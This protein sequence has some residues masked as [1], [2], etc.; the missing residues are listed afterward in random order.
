MASA[1]KTFPTRKKNCIRCC[2]R[3]VVQNHDDGRA[4]PAPTY[5]FVSR[6]RPCTLIIFQRPRVR[7][8]WCLGWSSM[9]HSRRWRR[10]SRPSCPHRGHFCGCTF[11]LRSGSTA[12]L[13]F[14]RNRTSFL[15]RRRRGR[16]SR[17]SCIHG[18]ILP[19]RPQKSHQKRIRTF[20]F[21]V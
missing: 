3:T 21:I 10:H 16:T 20:L 2:K 11:L 9:F 17:A 1:R 19:K 4:I 12:L 13:F 5:F 7:P 6:C 14:P 15:L 8:D 18:E